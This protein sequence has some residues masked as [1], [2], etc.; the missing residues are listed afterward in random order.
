MPLSIGKMFCCSFSDSTAILWPFCFIPLSSVIRNEQVLLIE[1]FI[2]ILE[3]PD[4]LTAVAL[5]IVQPSLEVSAEL[6]TA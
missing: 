1:L 4:P 6:P 3:L 5:K 2:Q